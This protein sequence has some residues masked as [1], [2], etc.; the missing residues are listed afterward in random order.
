EGGAVRLRVRHRGPAGVRPAG[1][2][3]VEAPPPG[4]HLHRHRD[5][6]GE[7]AAARTPRPARPEGWEPADR[8]AGRPVTA[9][10]EIKLGD[11][12]LN[13]LNEVRFKVEK[14][15]ALSDGIAEDFGAKMSGAKPGDV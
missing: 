1:L 15:L 10:V 14:Q 4:P 6:A 7:E 12:V 5:R 3:G 11:R 8:R 13:S 2:Q 9:D